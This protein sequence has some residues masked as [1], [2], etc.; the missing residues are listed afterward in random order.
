[1]AA[2]LRTFRETSWR[3][4]RALRSRVLNEMAAR[5]E[6]RTTELIQLVSLETG[7]VVPEAAFEVSLAASGLRYYSV[8][9]SPKCWPLF[10]MKLVD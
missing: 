3:N 9:D 4:D 5:F 2:A 7:K 8:S 6:A 10:R 1:M